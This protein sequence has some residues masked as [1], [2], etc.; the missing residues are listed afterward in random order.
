MCVFCFFTTKK[1]KKLLQRQ[2]C[3]S[4]CVSMQMRFSAERHGSVPSVCRRM[5]S[6]RCDRIKFA[7]DEMEKNHSRSPDGPRAILCVIDLVFELLG[8]NQF[9]LRFSPTEAPLS[10]LGDFSI[11][12]FRRETKAR[13]L[14]VL[15][16]SELFQMFRWFL[17][18]VVRILFLTPQSC[19]DCYQLSRCF[20]SS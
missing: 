4:V 20:D 1:N 5:Q 2:K 15:C 19:L 6:G 10:T 3:A 8:N 7:T 16:C 9:L 18:T 14:Y 13:L 11:L 17:I 12:L